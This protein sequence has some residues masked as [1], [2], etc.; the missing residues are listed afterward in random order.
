[1][2]AA[3]ARGLLTLAT[4]NLMGR[5]DETR[6]VW[7]DG[8]AE[9]FDALYLA[10]IANTVAAAMRALEEIDQLLEKVHADCE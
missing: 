2:S 6:L 10:E 7:R 3:A 1:M 4:R 5:W 8:K 9:E